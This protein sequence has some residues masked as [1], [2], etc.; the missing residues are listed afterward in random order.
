MKVNYDRSHLL[1]ITND[2]AS[3]KLKDFDIKN[4]IEEI[5]FGINFDTQLTF[6]S[7]VSF[8]CKK[9][10]QKLHVLAMM[11]S[12]IGLEKKRCLMKAFTFLSLALPVNLDVSQSKIKQPNK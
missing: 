11:V 5:L 7:Y 6:E 8:L 4:N 2:P 1:V 3:T 12:Y 10:S 9:A